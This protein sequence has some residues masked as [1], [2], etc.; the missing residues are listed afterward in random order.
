M[1]KG[2]ALKLMRKAINDAEGCGHVLRFSEPPRV[3]FNPETGERY[4]TEPTLARLECSEA[5]MRAIWSVWEKL[6]QII[7]AMEAA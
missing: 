2:E 3:R 4:L 6:P 1:T 7:G 5:K